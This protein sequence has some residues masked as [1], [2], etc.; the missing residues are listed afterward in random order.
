MGFAREGFQIVGS[1][2][3]DDLAALSHAINFHRN[4]EP[5]KRERH[6][7]ARDITAT[8]PAELAAELQLGDT[9]GCVDVIVGGP[10]CQSYA[11]VGRAKLREVNDHPTAFKIDPR[12]NL[13]LR[14]LEYVRAFVTCPHMIRCGK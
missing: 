2:E 3:H 6:R 1:V 5:K 7:K 13:Y 9:A 11:R 14:Y 12:G 4:D 10:P 8:T